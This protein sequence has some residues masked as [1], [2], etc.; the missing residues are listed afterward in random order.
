M[1][2]TTIYC[3]GCRG[4]VPISGHSQECVECGRGFGR[5]GIEQ[6]IESLK[7]EAEM[8]Q[9]QGILP[10]SVSD[11][12]DFADGMTVE[13]L[14]LRRSAEQ[15]DGLLITGEKREEVIRRGTVQ[16]PT[17]GIVVATCPNCGAT[18]TEV[19]PFCS[20][21]GTETTVP[22]PAVMN[23]A[24]ASE[25]AALEIRMN[26]KLSQLEAKVQDAERAGYDGWR[27]ANINQDEKWAVWWGVF[28]RGAVISGGI[29]L[30]I[31]LFA[32]VAAGSS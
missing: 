17:S 11:L 24:L 14:S 32:V 15:T 2:R 8:R 5:Q 25:M 9:K 26:R 3:V 19:V 16:A 30:I 22:E 12:R 10:I 27:W 18:Y 28:W 7:L 1:S 23:K 31:F 13:L 4:R 29:S 21:C 6:G 20:Q